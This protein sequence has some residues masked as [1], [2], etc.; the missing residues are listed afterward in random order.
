[1]SCVKQEPKPQ[2]PLEPQPI[3]TDSTLVDSTLTIKGETWV[4]TKVM[5]T[6]YHYENRSDT[7]YFIDKEHY[8]F[9][10]DQSL[11]DLDL[12]STYYILT[13]YDTKTNNKLTS[14]EYLYFLDSLLL[15]ANTI[16]NIQND[17]NQDSMLLKYVSKQA[18]WKN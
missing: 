3:I 5:Y 13:F 4:I 1:M 9:N 15:V 12:T 11:Y 14:N 2:L 8:T 6:D 10:G 7:L 17:Q 18:I 16:L